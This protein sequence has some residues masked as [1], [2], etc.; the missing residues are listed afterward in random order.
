MSMFIKIPIRNVDKGNG[1]LS[2]GQLDLP[3]ILPE[4]MI[5]NRFN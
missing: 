1:V 3:L 5:I 4:N 2:L